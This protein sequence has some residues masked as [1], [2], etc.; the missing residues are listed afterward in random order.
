MCR[1]GWLAV[2]VVGAQLAFVAGPARS[3]DSGVYYYVVPQSTVFSNRFSTTR[4]FTTGPRRQSVVV[5]QAL[6]PA[7]LT[8]QL[9]ITRPRSSDGDATP[10]ASGG[11]GAGGGNT[12]SDCRTETASKFQTD[13]GEAKKNLCALEEKHGLPK[14]SCEAL[15]G[16][17]SVT[18]PVSADPIDLI[19][20]LRAEI[21]KEMRLTVADRRAI[22]RSLRGKKRLDIDGVRETVKTL[23]EIARAVLTF[24]P[25]GLPIEKQPIWLG[26]VDKVVGLLDSQPH[27]QSMPVAGAGLVDRTTEMITRD[28]AA[29]FEP[30]PDAKEQATPTGPLLPIS[31]DLPVG[32]FGP[33]QT[34]G[35]PPRGMTPPPQFDLAPPPPPLNEEQVR[36]IVEEQVQASV[37]SELKNA[38]TEHFGDRE[39]FYGQV[40]KMI[41][42]E[43]VRS[44]DADNPP[45]P[46]STTPVL[47]STPAAEAAPKPEAAPQGQA[48]PKPEAAPKREAAPQSEAK[49]KPEATPQSEAKSKA[50]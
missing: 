21:N 27:L 42:E 34:I 44:K 25:V 20:A 3:Q 47:Q 41:Q 11:G 14:G 29:A 39:A 30:A 46:S 10:P 12:N 17:G 4:R 40:R 26:L 19:S 2:V 50:R 37:A 6:S 43:L 24:A 23:S 1:A 33:P 7:D 32:P 36:K 9:G 38:F 18:K 48:K 35:P 8:D 22:A 49:P 45:G 31:D 13:I 5:N 15:K 16:S 28:L